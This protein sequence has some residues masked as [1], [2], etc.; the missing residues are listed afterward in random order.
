MTRTSSMWSDDHSD[1]SRAAAVSRAATGA[2]KGAWRTPSLRNVANTAPYMHDG[3]YATL[4]EVVAHYSRGPDPSAVG[5]PAA[6][7]K[8]LLLTDGEQSDLVAF[9]QTLSSDVTSI[10]PTGSVGATGMG[11]GGGASGTAGTSGG[12]RGGASGGRGGGG[13]GPPPP[14]AACAGMP[15]ATSEIIG[16][17]LSPATVAYTYQGAGLPSVSLDQMIAPDGSLQAIHVSAGSLEATDPANAYVGFGVS[18]G[19]PSCLDARA[20]NSF[21]FS[22]AGTVTGC[23][24]KASL[25]TSEDNSIQYGSSGA[26]TLAAAMC[27]PPFSS[28]LDVPAPGSPLS[29]AVCFADLTGGNPMLAIDPGALN[30][31][32]WLFNVPTDGSSCSFDVTIS[33][34]SFASDPSCP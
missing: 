10:A 4:A 30:G 18:F 20:F 25:V 32:Q 9:L 12:G 3:V 24:L 22:I 34:V 15:P 6:D 27:V 16:S 13:G 21:V 26:C 14:P 33:Q 23:A 7:I 31:V 8:P 17:T 2:L 19:R 11:G 29:V 1:T 5:T 28:V